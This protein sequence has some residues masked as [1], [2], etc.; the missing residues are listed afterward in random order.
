MIESILPSGQMVIVKQP[1]QEQTR[2]MSTIAAKVC[3]TCGRTI[4]YRKKWARNW[5]EIK[6]CGEKCR[7]NKNTDNFEAQILELLNK[8]GSGKTICPS[9]VLEGDDKTN[10]ELMEKVRSSARLLVAKGKIIITQNGR[11]V[12]PSTARGAIRLRLVKA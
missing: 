5:S 7:R 3:V 8:R 12:D 10:K 1:A 6:H 11:V 4:E 2:K 9:E